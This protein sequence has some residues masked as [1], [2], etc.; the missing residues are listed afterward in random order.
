MMGSGGGYYGA[1]GW[2]WNSGYITTDTHVNFEVTLWDTH[3][4]GKMLWSST[5]TTL[6]PSDGKD[7]ADSLAKN[8]IPN[9]MKDGFLPR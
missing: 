8:V 2:G 7:F 9:L 5:T 6:N 4:D 3:G 1:G